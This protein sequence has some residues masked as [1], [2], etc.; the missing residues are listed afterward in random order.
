MVCFHREAPVAAGSA[1]ACRLLQ[2][3]CSEGWVRSR[4]GERELPWAPFSSVPRVCLPA[5]SHLCDLLFFRVLAERHVA[6]EKPLNFWLV[7]WLGRL[8]LPVGLLSTC[9]CYTCPLSQPCRVFCI[10]SSHLFF[11]LAPYACSHYAMVPL[12]SLWVV[13]G[14]T[15]LHPHSARGGCIIFYL[16]ASYSG[17][18]RNVGI[19]QRKLPSILFTLRS[20]D[21]LPLLQRKHPSQQL[22]GVQF[23]QI[24]P[25]NI[26]WLRR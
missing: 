21:L 24:L 15:A 13:V 18:L 10:A 6:E 22:D 26:L 16:G 12:R 1:S 20:K 3:L 2:S 25:N 14:R 4:R 23:V 7:K 11:V 8:A 17:T 9:L 19:L 5:R